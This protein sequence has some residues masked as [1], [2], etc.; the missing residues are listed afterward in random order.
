MAF[1]IAATQLLG[2][3]QAQWPIIAIYGSVLATDYHT[4][5]GG[6]TS[7]NKETGGASPAVPFT[8]RHQGRMWG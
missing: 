1:F 6:S 5:M 3:Y 4:G 2:A 7:H 8:N